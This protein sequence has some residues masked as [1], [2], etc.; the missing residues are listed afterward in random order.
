MSGEG[1]DPGVHD[2]SQEIAGAESF[3][4]HASPVPT[5]ELA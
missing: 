2:R 1:H 5:T 3:G 4:Y